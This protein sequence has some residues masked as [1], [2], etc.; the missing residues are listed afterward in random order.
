M[1]NLRTL[2]LFCPS[3]METCPVMI[4][5]TVPKNNFATSFACPYFFTSQR[6]SNIFFVSLLMFVTKLV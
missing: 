4:S 1:K 2:I 3:E 6:S 5:S